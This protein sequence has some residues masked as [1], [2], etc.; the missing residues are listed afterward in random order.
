MWNPWLAKDIDSL[1]KVHEICYSLADDYESHA[2]LGLAPCSLE[3]WREMVNLWEVYK[4]AHGL[5]QDRVNNLF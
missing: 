2:C 1:E 3:K 4:Y 5:Y